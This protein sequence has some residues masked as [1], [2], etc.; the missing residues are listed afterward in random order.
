MALY[1]SRIERTEYSYL[2]SYI[3]VWDR[4]ALP[5]VESQIEGCVDNR[6]GYGT[7]EAA[8]RM[9]ARYTHVQQLGYTHS[10]QTMTLASVAFVGVKF[11]HLRHHDHPTQRYYSARYDLGDELHRIKSGLKLAERL[12]RAERKYYPDSYRMEDADQLVAVLRRLRAKQ[13]D[14]VECDSSSVVGLLYCHK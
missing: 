9:L 3:H 10:D 13:V 11:E 8:Q 7:P 12:E 5:T 1:F 2:S 6:A 14:V 4:E